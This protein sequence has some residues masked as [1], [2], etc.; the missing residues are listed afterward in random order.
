VLVPKTLEDLALLDSSEVENIFKEVAEFGKTQEAGTPLEM[1]MSNVV[2]SRSNNIFYLQENKVNI[3]SL[4]TNRLVLTIN[5]R[6]IAVVYTTPL[7]TLLFIGT[8]MGLFEARDPSTLKI[9]KTIMLKNPVIAIVS[10]ED[11]VYVSLRN[12]DLVYFSIKEDFTEENKKYLRRNLE[13]EDY[14]SLLKLSKDNAFLVAYVDIDEMETFTVYNCIKKEKTWSSKLDLA[15]GQNREDPNKLLVISDDCLS[16]FARGENNKGVTM[17]SLFDGSIITNLTGM[18]TNYIF[19]ILVSRDSKTVIT[20]SKDKKIK[21]WDW[22]KQTMI[23]Q[24]Q[25]H[26]E[27]V[28]SIVLSANEKLLFSASLDKKVIVWSL[29]SYTQICSFSTDF[30]IRTLEL[31]FENDYLVALSKESGQ[32]ELKL[33]KAAFWI[34]EK[35]EGAFR[36]NVPLKGITGCYVTPD[37]E[38]MVSMTKNEQVTLWNIKSRTMI[39]TFQTN[40]SYW[41]QIRPINGTKDSRFIFFQ[42]EKGEVSQWEC[43]T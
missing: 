42:K 41:L 3:W 39:T 2:L 4:T 1:E 40:T 29:Y 11:T 7:N 18:H 28:E 9:K 36:I 16:I 21:V 37:S 12:G 26:N 15:G 35:N 34:L 24:L 43:A 19:Q 31:S 23:V 14:Y 5:K 20:C 33:Q 6:G 22:L 8:K 32:N 13:N 10:D 38:F 17:Y 30:P 25:A 27:A